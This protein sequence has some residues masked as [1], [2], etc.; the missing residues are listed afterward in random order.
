MDHIL[1]VD[2]H[3]VAVEVESCALEV[4]DYLNDLS[5]WQQPIFPDVPGCSRLELLPSYFNTSGTFWNCDN[6]LDAGEQYC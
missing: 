3:H 4:A 6:Q 5:N 1:K 2:W